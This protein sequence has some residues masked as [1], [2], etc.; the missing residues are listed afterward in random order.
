E[1]VEGRPEEM[2]VS[3]LML[4]SMQQAKYDP[5][6]IGHFGLATDFYTHFTAPIR[7]YPDLIVHRLIRMYLLRGQL[8]GNTV[9][10]WKTTLPNIATQASD[11][12]R[13]AVD[14]ERETDDL[15]KAEYMMHKIGQTYTRIISSVTSFGMFVELANTVE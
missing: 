8:D 6:S 9:A 13:V 7:R 12:E 1:R 2:V 5:E 10:A 11:R 14:A 3:K 15:K 4:R